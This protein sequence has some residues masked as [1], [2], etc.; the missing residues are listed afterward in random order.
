M[1]IPTK[2]IPFEPSPVSEITSKTGMQKN[3]AEIILASL[4]NRGLLFSRKIEGGETGYALQQFGFGFPQTFFWGGLGSPDAK[5]MAGLIARY[6]RR[7]E[8]HKI[9]GSTGTK[10]F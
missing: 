10:A 9:Y 2:I 5:K 8:L 3:E 1:A 6:A 4:A 7:D